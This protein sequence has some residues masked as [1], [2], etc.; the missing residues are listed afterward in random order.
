MIIVAGKVSSISVSKD[1][2]I[3]L[4]V[5]QGVLEA[6]KLIVAAGIWTPELLKDLGIELVIIL[7]AHPYAHGPVGHR[8]K[9]QQPFVR[10]P[11]RHVYARDHEEFNG[12]RGYDQEPVPRAPKENAL[13]ENGSD[14]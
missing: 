1:A 6:N 10:W 2:K 4:T 13:F 5:D 8:R 12:F 9:K 11:E 3:S 7:V 14:P